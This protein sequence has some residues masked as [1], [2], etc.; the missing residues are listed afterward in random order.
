MEQPPPYSPPPAL[1]TSF[2]RT[3]Y[4][5]WRLKWE[6]LEKEVLWR[7]A[8]DGIAGANA[9]VQPR[10]RCR[11]C[12]GAAALDPRAHCFWDCPVALAVRHAI[13]A[14]LL[15]A[16]PV[17]SRASIWLCQPPQGV[18]IGVWRVVCLAALSA[19]EHGRRKL[20]GFGVDADQAA[21]TIAATRQHTLEDVWGMPAPA[22]APCPIARASNRA[23]TDFWGRLTS[24]ATLRLAP[25]SWLEPVGTD[26][27]FLCSGGVQIRMGPASANQEA[28][29]AALP[30]VAAVPPVP[31]PRVAAFRQRPLEEFWQ[32]RSQPAAAARMGGGVAGALLGGD[33]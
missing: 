11:C 8:V 31:A 2:A 6:N 16:T 1:L 7:L 19:M 13:A 12:P 10:F 27:P 17:V 32:R 3:L 26:H 30:A 33:G 18:H 9:Y 24:F 20:W 5:L 21:A 22:A 25:D 29:A 14:A 23:V 15:P 28:A 4:S